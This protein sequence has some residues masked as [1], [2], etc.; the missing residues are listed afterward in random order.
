[1]NRR[2]MMASLSGLAALA[3]VNA[4]AAPRAESLSSAAG[5]GSSLSVFNPRQFGAVGDGKTLDTA[6]INAAIDACTHAGGGTVYLPPGTYLCGSVVLKSHVTLYLEAGATV[7]GSANVADFATRLDDASAMTEKK[8]PRHLIYAKGADHIGICGP[9][10][11]DGQGQSYWSLKN[12]PPVVNNENRWRNAVQWLWDAR[13]R[14]SPMVVLVGCTNV[15]LEDVRVENAPAWTIMFNNCAKVVVHSIAI[16][17]PVYGPNCDG[18]DIVSSQD[19]MIS[20]C[21][22]DTGDDAIC[23][24]S[25]S[26]W[27]PGGLPSLTKNIVVTNC[28]ISGCCNGFKIGTGSFGGFENITFSNS[29]IYNDEVDLPSRI[30]SGIALEIVDG[31]WI[32]GVVISGIQM[33]RVR[34]PIFIRRGNRS[35]KEDH[36]QRRLRGVLIQGIHATD[37]IMTS[38]IIGIPSMPIEDVSLSGIHIDTIFPG[39]K[40]W[41]NNPIPE[42]EKLYPEVW[43]SGWLPASGLYC[44]HVKGLQ[45]KDLH[46]RAPANEWRSTVI[47]DSVSQLTLTGLTTTAVVGGIPPLGL[48]SVSSAW[49]SAVAAPAGS[50]ALLSVQGAQSADI[51]VS[52]C[53]ARH[54]T[55]LAQIDHDVQPAVLHAEFNITSSKI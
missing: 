29:V 11:I 28:I 8:L 12:Q 18:I 46:F 39:H 22:I 6:A 42:S 13:D 2:N 5:P 48:N 54:A 50:Q 7:L 14:P 32:D 15:R 55:T 37:S 20:D 3:A 40:D 24:K 9:G 35:S 38:A 52:G 36:A 53:D 44:R 17:N 25:G 26:D 10:R 45:L 23:L 19:V 27:L 49:I 33:R 47:C 43:M 51:L 16:K 41:V 21:I 1:M 31:G 30:I 4:S 34:A